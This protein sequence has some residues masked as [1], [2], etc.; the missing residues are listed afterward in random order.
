[1][2]VGQG[3]TTVR[4]VMHKFKHGSL[5]SGSST[6]P[7]VTRADQAIAIALN[8]AGLSNPKKQKKPRKPKV[9]EF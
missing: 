7:T 3:K 8:E 4:D 2:P 9:E 5:H 1:M 6:G